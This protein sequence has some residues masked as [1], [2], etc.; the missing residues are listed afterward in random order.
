M[1]G[2][3]LSGGASSVA[4]T[5]GAQGTPCGKN[6]YHWD[7]PTTQVSDAGSSTV[8]VNGKPIA[9]VGDS[10]DSGAI[11]AGSPNVFANS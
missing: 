6:V 1:P 4:C 10:T 3:A 8:F 2:I 7:T 9:R 5:D 11:T